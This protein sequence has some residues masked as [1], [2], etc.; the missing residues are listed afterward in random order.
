MS[1]FLPLLD[2]LKIC[3]VDLVG[4]SNGGIIGLDI[5]MSRPERLDH[6]FAQAANMTTHGVDRKVAT[7]TLFGSYIDGLA[8]HYAVVAEAGSV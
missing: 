4:W 5:A 7:H 2:Y 8:K 1:D 6:L 3:K